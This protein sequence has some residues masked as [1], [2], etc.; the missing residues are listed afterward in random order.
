MVRNI[1]NWRNTFVMLA[2][3]LLSVF[4]L[5]IE[6]QAG[7]SKPQA[8]ITAAQVNKKNIE[9]FSDEFFSEYMNKNHIPGAAV[10]VVQN[11]KVIFKKGYG[12]SNI[13][14][15]TPVD[16]DKTVFYICS[17]GKTFTGTAVMQLYERNKLNLK[18]NVEKYIKSFKLKN[19]FS[20]PVTFD[21]LLTH[22]SGLDAGSDIGG[23]S[24]TR[25]S[26]LSY[27]EFMKLKNT[28]VLKEPDLNTRYSNFGFN[29][30]GF[31]VQKI[32]GMPYEEYLKK[33]ILEP[34]DMKNSSIGDLPDSAATPYAYVGKKYKALDT[35][36]YSPAAGDGCVN[37]TASDMCNFMIAHLQNG[38]YQGKRILKEETAK[39][40]HEQHYTSNPKM[41]G[42]AYAFIED[43]RNGQKAIKHEGGYAGGF[44]TTMYMIPDQKLGFFMA[45]N[46]ENIL[47]FKF[48]A[49][50]MDRFFPQKA[51]K[52]PKAPAGFK[53]RAGEYTGTY[54]SYDDIAVSTVGKM[55]CLLP[56]DGELKITDNG[57]GTLEMKGITLDKKMSADFAEFSTRLVEVGPM[58]FQREDDGSYI[59][60]N[61]NEKGK[62]EYLSDGEPFKTFEKLKWYETSGF[63]L[64]LLG[65]CLIVFLASLLIWVIGWVIRKFKG[66]PNNYSKPAKAARLVGGLVCFINVASLCGFCIMLM[67]V[68]Y[69]IQLGLPAQA[70]V[71]L[72]GFIAGSLLTAAAAVFAVLAWIKKFWSFAGRVH[73]TAVVLAGL[74][75]VWF[76]N[77]WNML[78]LKL[79]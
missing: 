1:K 8:Q 3:F 62:V 66:K 10:S 11:G 68:D 33:N 29:L 63:N 69:R 77:F 9:A 16:P 13:E 21:N 23:G 31:L 27:E 71:E 52:F 42:M 32:S 61:R 73:Y 35:K 15:K 64:L 20:K 39:F 37:A 72:T 49:E 24:R 55:I 47:P 40:M 14:K 30:L 48:E 76:L 4:A 6:A 41:P 57:D 79:Q 65:V 22:T 44:T 78:G 58:L 50:F 26:A 54:R 59:S 19:S 38:E 75:F 7:T 67:S 43:Y 12:Y 56:S 53:S 36:I 17:T 25:D 51:P 28:R 45:I 18:D 74:G 2:V 60:F 34:L 70:Y 5:S 46:C